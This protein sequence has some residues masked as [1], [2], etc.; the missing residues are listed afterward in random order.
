MFEELNSVPIEILQELAQNTE[1]SDQEMMYYLLLRG[2]LRFHSDYKTYPGLL[3]RDVE[4][5][6]NRFKGTF[7][8]LLNDW[9]ASITVK[10]DCIHELCRYGACELPSV[11]AF[12]GGCAA[13]EAIKIITKQYVPLDNT[14][15]Y[16]AMQSTSSSFNVSGVIS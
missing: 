5:D 8:K 2:L 15:I 10:E 7:T 1:Y 16:N 11:A 14:F 3:D 4:P 13:Q 6:I 9:N 12:I